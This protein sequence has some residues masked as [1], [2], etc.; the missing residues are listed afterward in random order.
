MKKKQKSKDGRG[1]NAH[2][3]GAFATEILMLEGDWDE[4]DQLHNGLVEDLK[5][6]GRMEEHLVLELAKLHWRKGR[7]EQLYVYE[8]DWLQVHPGEKGIEELTDI[9]RSLTKDASCQAI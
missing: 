7:L 6:S 8:A 3:H 9:I 5:P 4:F 2:K 1:T